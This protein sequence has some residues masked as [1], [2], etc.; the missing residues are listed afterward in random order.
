MPAICTFNE[1]HISLFLSFFFP[2]LLD[3]A[4]GFSFAALRENKWYKISSEK[5]SL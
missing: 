4:K 2:I 5:K 3:N 1:E